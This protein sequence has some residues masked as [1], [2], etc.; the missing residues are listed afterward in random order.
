MARL[1]VRLEAHLDGLRV[2]GPPG[3]EIAKAQLVEVGGPGE[4]FATAV[5]AFEGGDEAKVKEVLT[6]GVAT[7]RDR[8]LYRSPRV[9]GAGGRTAP[10]PAATQ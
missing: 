9:A 8:G 10:Y 2:A 6:A 4:V 1:D 3:W 5:L 7:P